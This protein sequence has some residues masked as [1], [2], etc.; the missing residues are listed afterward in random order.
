MWQRV[1]RHERSARG[2]HTANQARERP[3]H[4]T[5][6][7]LTAGVVVADER[8]G[9]RAGRHR[10]GRFRALTRRVHLDPGI[11]AKRMD[12]GQPVVGGGVPDREAREPPTP[13]HPQQFVG[14]RRHRVWTKRG[15]V[16]IRQGVANQEVVVRVVAPGE[17]AEGRGHTPRLDV[18][19]ARAPRPDA[20]VERVRVGQSAVLA[21]NLRQQRDAVAR[22]H[23]GGD[24]EDQHPERRV[25][26]VG[27]VEEARVGRAVRRVPPDARAACRGRDVGADGQPLRPER[28]RLG[29]EHLR[30]DGQA[31]ACHQ[32]DQEHGKNG[33]PAVRLHAS[34]VKLSL[35]R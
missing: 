24:A 27:V 4:H 13:A 20:H 2:G 35:T 22:L 19:A 32:H 23:L 29:R 17:G 28:Q 18:E 15:E 25:L 26:I 30:L 21:A 8:V 6:G 10:D 9:E 16:L 12:E 34:R 11:P 5:S 3:H 33:P 14:V 31:A 1:G 7:N